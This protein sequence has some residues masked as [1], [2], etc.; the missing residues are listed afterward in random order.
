MSFV[1]NVLPFARGST[2]TDNSAEI[3]Q[4]DSTYSDLEGRLYVVPDTENATGE[5]VVLRCVKNDTGGEIT[6]TH[7]FYRYSTGAKDW[8]RRIAGVCNAAGMVGKP[9]DDAFTV[10]GT[11]EKFGLFYLVESGPCTLRPES[12]A[13]N[14]AAG[15]P[16]ATDSSGRANGAAAAAGEAVLATIDQACTA[17]DTEVLFHIRGDVHEPPASG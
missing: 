10:G 4:D 2:M 15:D 12:S 14:L 6:A 5:P 3:T 16:V 17:T 7:D 11:I 13:V 9:M 8:G 1:D